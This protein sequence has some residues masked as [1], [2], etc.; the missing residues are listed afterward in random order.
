MCDMDKKNISDVI[1]ML[2][3]R[4]MTQAEIAAEI[5]VPQPLICRWEN[6]DAPPAAQTTLDLLALAE[7]KIKRS[8]KCK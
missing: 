7:R 6:G 3:A 1:K 4:P 5:K 2:R 8:K